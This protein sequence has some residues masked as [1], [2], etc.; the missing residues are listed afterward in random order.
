MAYILGAQT[1]KN[2][3]GFTRRQIETGSAN[4]AINGRTTKDIRNRKEQFVLTYEN[5]SNTDR[6]NILSEY[7]LETTRDFQVTEPNLTIATTPVHIDIKERTYQKGADYLE[8]LTLIL[9]EVD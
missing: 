6:N 7:D 8:F 5:L 4:N 2:P 3:A 9:T 1:L